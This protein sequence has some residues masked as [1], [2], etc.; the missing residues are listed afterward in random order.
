M[1]AL[2]R[3]LRAAAVVAPIAL[4]LLT[5]PSVGSCDQ[6]GHGC[7]AI[8]CPGYGLDIRFDGDL[9][10]N[11]A[12]DIEVA[13]VEQS[14]AVPIITCVLSSSPGADGDTERLL[15][16]SKQSIRQS[17]PRTLNTNSILQTVRVT[18][19]SNGTQLAQQTVSPQ[20][21]RSA[22][23]GPDCGECVFGAIQVALPQPSQP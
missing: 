18:I 19:S 15:C 7:T 17:G 22:P 11:T 1:I 23:N 4:F 6:L 21:T 3:F 20:Y 12:L 8:G 16:T 2:S 9:A 14:G 10:S 13:M 5:L